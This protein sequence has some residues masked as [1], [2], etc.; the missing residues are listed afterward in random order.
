MMSLSIVWYLFFAGVGSGVFVVTVIETRYLGFGGSSLEAL[1]LSD[2][3]RARAA[4]GFCAA[5]L[6]MVIA[7]VFLVF[8][9]GDPLNA[10]RVFLV[11]FSTITAFG[12][13][14]VM[15][16]TAATVAL[17]LASVMLIAIPRW[18]LVCARVIG[19]PLAVVTMV[20][21]GMLLAGMPAVAVWRTWLVPVLF[22]VSSLACGL[23]AFLF[24]EAFLPDAR[25]SSLASWQTHLVLGLLEAALLA[26]FVFERT[27]AAPAAHASV[28]SLLTG[29]HA[30]AFWLG[31]VAVGLVVPVLIHILYRWMPTEALVVAASLC[32]LVGAFFL[33]LCVVGIALHTPLFP[34]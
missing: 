13:C 27:G 18:L 25:M 24:A 20:Y 31:V 11:P 10:W 12:A 17:A 33:R 21:A 4:V 30:V 29:E 14:C 28:Q 6:S 23:A 5:A 34:V 22:V 3:T 7:S 19:V 15:L 1:S 9:L 2:A 32:V 26:A 8:D 16:F